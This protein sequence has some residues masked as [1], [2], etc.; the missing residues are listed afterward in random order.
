MDMVE[1]NLE[2]LHLDVERLVSETSQH[3]K[4][5][6]MNG[7]V[8]D[9]ARL[10]I[11]DG[12]DECAELVAHGLC[13][14]AGGSGLEVELALTAKAGGVATWHERVHAARARKRWSARR[15]RRRGRTHW[16]K[17]SSLFSG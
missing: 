1:S 16:W 12:V 8:A 7:S 15:R 6:K 11:L 4:R 3:R 14:D 17:A 9:L 5:S 10:G 13:C 2:R